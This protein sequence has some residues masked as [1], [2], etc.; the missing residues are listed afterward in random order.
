MGCWWECA[1]LATSSSNPMVQDLRLPPDEFERLLS[2]VAQR[3]RDKARVTYRTCRRTRVDDMQLDWDG[4]GGGTSAVTRV[5]RSSAEVAGRWARMRV[6]HTSLPLHAFPSSLEDVRDVAAVG[7][8][9]ISAPD[10]GAQL[11]FE[12]QAFGDGAPPVFRVYVRASTLEQAQ[13]MGATI[14]EADQAPPP[15]VDSLRAML[16]I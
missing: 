13:A 7:T 6:E 10:G 2:F 9:T 15:D 12:Q 5:K 3:A 11:C 1:F 16:Q 14:D 8:I 4:D